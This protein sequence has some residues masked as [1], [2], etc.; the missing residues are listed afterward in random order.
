MNRILYGN[1]SKIVAIGRNFP[2]H[3]LEMGDVSTRAS[4]LLFLKPSTSIVCSE[5]QA[6]PVILPR[7]AEV[8]HEVELAVVVGKRACRVPWY[9]ASQY[10][11]GYCVALDLTARNWQHEAKSNGEP[12]TRSKGLDGFLPLGTFVN[13]SDSPALDDLE[14]CLDVNDECRQRD[15]LKHMTFSHEE[16]LSYASTVMTLLPGDMIL[17]GT[18]NGVGPLKPGDTARAYLLDP[19]QNNRI[20]S[21][22]QI[23]CHPDHR[24]EIPWRRPNP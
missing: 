10:V 23:T 22:L 15:A 16:L 4:P 1:C 12:W 8:H 17:C 7:G 13:Q 2:A 5:R 11:A 14:L 18:P 3:A 20:L 6:S 21:K 9:E 24:P 19:Q